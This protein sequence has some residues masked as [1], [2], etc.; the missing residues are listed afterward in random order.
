MEIPEHGKLSNNNNNG[1]EAHA[2]PVTR[3]PDGVCSLLMSWVAL[4]TTPC[5]GKKVPLYFRL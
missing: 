1:S 4:E 3:W 5:P 2:V